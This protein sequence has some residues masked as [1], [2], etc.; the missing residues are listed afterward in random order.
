MVF[1]S[2]C[3]RTVSA[4]RMVLLIAVTAAAGLVTVPAQAS[5]TV[6]IPGGN[7]VG[8][9]LLGQ[10]WARLYSLPIPSNPL[11]GAGDPC[12]RIVGGTIL[13]PVIT[14]GQPSFTCT[15]RLGTPVLLMSFS[16][17]CSALE[18]P[19][20]VSAAAQRA[21]AEELDTS[22]G[23]HS[24]LYA[25]DGGAPIEFHARAFETSSRQETV[26]LP[27]DNLAG[28]APGPDTFVAHGWLGLV[29]FLLPGRHVIHHEAASDVFS[30]TGSYEIVVTRR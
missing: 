20:P 27:P 24:S 6:I 11:F 8:G 7:P 15:V 3:R 5:G 14:P 13:A 12:Q 9:A 23:V 25:I 17:A 4:R 26:Q 19:F 28:A 22:A 21:C 2:H 16:A 18:P 29:P 1:R 30:G 10:W